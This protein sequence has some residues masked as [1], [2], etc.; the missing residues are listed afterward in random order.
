MTNVFKIAKNFQQKSLEEQFKNEIDNKNN[1]MFEER[2][3][4]EMQENN[5][6]TIALVQEE[7]ILESPVKTSFFVIT[8]IF[9]IFSGL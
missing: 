5:V 8:F 3:V 9:N 1:I 6:E 4:D 2:I 7:T